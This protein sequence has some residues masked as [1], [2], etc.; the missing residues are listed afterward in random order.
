MSGKENQINENLNLVIQLIN[1]AKT[2][3]GEAENHNYLNN[4]LCNL[5]AY[6]RLIGNDYQQLAN[7]YSQSAF[8]NE[9][10][11]DANLGKKQQAL[12]NAN[13]KI[14]IACHHIRFAK[15]LQ[16]RKKSRK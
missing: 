11:A 9:Q 16:D 13:E 2:E 1:E 10:E 12:I 6:F 3:M 14:Q 8:E 7:H 4:I 15:Y 5:A